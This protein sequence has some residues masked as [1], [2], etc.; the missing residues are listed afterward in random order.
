MLL[1]Q[2]TK[3]GDKLTISL[4]GQLD[5]NSAQDLEE[6]I[7]DA[8]KGIRHLVFDLE[9]LTFISSAG[10][11]ILLY[12]KKQIGGRGKMEIINISHVVYEVFEVTGF[13]GMLGIE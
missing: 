1:I 10:L 3:K 5:T 2:K 7:D 11:R 12:A 13:A 6:M 8:I 4:E 9:K